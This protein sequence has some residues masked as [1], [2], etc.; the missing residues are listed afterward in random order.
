MMVEIFTAQFAIPTAISLAALFFSY[1]ANK[2][3]KEAAMKSQEIQERFEVY[4]F[5]P[6]L[7]I[8]AVPG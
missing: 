1:I 3:S 7:S 4:Q 5:Y 2:N 6:I 8:K